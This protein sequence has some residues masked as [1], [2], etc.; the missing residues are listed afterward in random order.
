[1]VLPHPLK[2]NLQIESGINSC[3][4]DKIPIAINSEVNT[5]QIQLNN[6]LCRCNKVVNLSIAPKNRLDSKLINLIFV[7]TIM[8]LALKM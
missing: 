7:F 3:I 5:R 2:I 1:M 8:P 6:F 4:I